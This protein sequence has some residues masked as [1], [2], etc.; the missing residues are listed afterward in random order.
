MVNGRRTAICQTEVVQKSLSISRML[1]SSYTLLRLDELQLQFHYFGMKTISFYR[2]PHSEG[3]AIPAYET[4]GAA[5]MDL[6]A[7]V[8]EDA[9]IN[10]APGM[11]ALIPTG[12]ICAIPDGF[13]GQ[14]RPRSGLAFKHGVTVL[15]APGT[16]D[17][18]YRGEL[19]VLLINHGEVNF[20]ITRGMRIAQLIIVPVT[21]LQ[22]VE[23][24]ELPEPTQRG[25]G[26][27]GSTG[28]D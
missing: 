18:D 26:G 10:L 15:N 19:M 9:A 8:P 12:F 23:S 24:A 3:I 11:R 25:E 7:S 2:L 28:I 20:E 5:G 21:Q 17:C 22:P 16:I 6:P 1:L 14:I 13:E 27:F 4:S